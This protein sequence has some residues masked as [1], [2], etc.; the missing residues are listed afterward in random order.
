MRNTTDRLRFAL[1]MMTAV[2]ILTIVGVSTV[3]YSFTLV[4]RVVVEGQL[5][6]LRGRRR[7]TRRINKMTGR[8]IVCGRGRVGAAVAHDLAREGH[9]VVVIDRS[10]DRVRDLFIVA[11][12]RADE[13]IPKLTHAG[14][15]RV[16]NPQEL[17]VARMASCVSSPNVAEFIDVVMHERSIEFR[18]REFVDTESCNFTTNPTGDHRLEPGHV[19][20]AVGTDEDLLR[21]ETLAKSTS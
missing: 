12:A 2:T 17:G 10:L 9:D 21:L 5:K 8:T 15:H 11:R 1:G 3:L 19:L 7:M 16:A 14:A 20:V 6:E 13:S 18:M 4:V